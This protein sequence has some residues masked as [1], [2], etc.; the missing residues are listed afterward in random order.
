MPHLISAFVIHLQESIVSK[1][2]TSKISSFKLVSVAEQVGVQPGQKPG[3]QVFLWRGPASSVV[4]REQE[5][6]CHC[7][8]SCGN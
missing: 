7:N 8:V 3:R 6:F 5:A 4:L 1:L 2:S